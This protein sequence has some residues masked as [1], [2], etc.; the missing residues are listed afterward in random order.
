[1]LPFRLRFAAQRIT[2]PAYY[3]RLSEILRHPST[4]YTTLARKIVPGW[5]SAPI[6]L[7]LKDGK[8]FRVKEFWSLFVFD[9][10][11]VQNCY[12]SPEV[13]KHGPFARV[14]D[15][16]ANVGLF[17]LRCKQLWPEARM[18]A[19]EPH[20]D[21]FQHLQEHIAI[22]QLKDVLPVQMGLAEKCGCFELYLSPRN[23]GGHSMYKTTGSSGSITISTSTLADVMAQTY[24][25]YGG[26]TLLKIDC[27]G[28][29]YPVLSNLTQEMADGIS[30]I[31]FEPEHSL[32]NLDDLLAKLRS[33]G[34]ET[35]RF[36]SIVVA[37]KSAAKS[38]SVADAE[39]LCG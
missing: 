11:F 37:A 35:S 14:L 12:E 7:R 8:L 19:I 5:S 3:R 24:S 6:D 17:T 18:V 13:L 10:I 25:P 30:C 2:S 26:P 9:E 22:N 20:P 31:V 32:Y 15:I 36:S 34:F 27:E 23:I 1:M 4:F 21:N 33:F 39:R 29:E 38:W 28:C 16:G